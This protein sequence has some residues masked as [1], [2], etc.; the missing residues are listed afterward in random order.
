[1]WGHKILQIQGLFQHALPPLHFD[2]KTLEHCSG[3]PAISSE[4]CSNAQQKHL[5]TVER[6]RFGAFS[7]YSGREYRIVPSGKYF[8]IKCKDLSK[9]RLTV[10]RDILFFH[11]YSRAVFVM[12]LSPL[13]LKKFT[14][15]HVAF[16]P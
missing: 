11:P 7:S 16:S 8:I 15:P 10:F 6:G 9:Q 2:P 4:H 5:S 1:M 13:G 12:P 14:M 3:G